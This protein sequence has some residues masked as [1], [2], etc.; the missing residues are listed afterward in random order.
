GFAQPCRARRPWPGIVRRHRSGRAVRDGAPGRRPAPG[1]RHPV[2]GYPWYRRAHRAA[3]QHRA[4]RSRM[5]RPADPRGLPRAR[6]RPEARS[7]G[8][9]MHRDWLRLRLPLL[10]ALGCSLLVGAARADPRICMSADTLS[11]GQ[12]AV[13]TSTAA[14]VTVSNCGD[15]AFVLTDVSPHAATNPAYR[16]ESDCTTGMTLAPRDQ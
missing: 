9:P 8:R 5:G 13:G 15:A 12:H 6:A 2:E 16:I 10:F 7:V 1:P 11:C 3:A 4:R 14:S